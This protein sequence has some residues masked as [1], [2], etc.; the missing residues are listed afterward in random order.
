MLHPLD[1]PTI[2]LAW[3][4]LALLLLAGCSGEEPTEDTDLDTDSDT[5]TADTDAGA[6]GFD[7]RNITVAGEIGPSW[8]VAADADVEFVYGGQWWNSADCGEACDAVFVT[9]VGPEITTCNDLASVGPRPGG[10][11]DVSFNSVP[12]PLADGT[13]D[14]TA[15]LA[16]GISCDNLL[17][18]A[19]QAGVREKIGDLTIEGGGDTDDTDSGGTDDTDAG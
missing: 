4:P 15:V 18:D 3:M 2:R 7:L 1:R 19:L 12:I 8:T 5:D 9:E 14:V 10:T 16:E 17:T 6:A 11:L 13:Y